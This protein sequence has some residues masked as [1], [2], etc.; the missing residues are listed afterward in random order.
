MIYEYQALNK[1]IGSHSNSANS[2][3]NSS[4]NNIKRHSTV[5]SNVIFEITDSSLA[6][7]TEKALAAISQQENLLFCGQDLYDSIG[8]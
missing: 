6:R 2:E 3:S 4:S 7:R 1:K 8:V 5:G